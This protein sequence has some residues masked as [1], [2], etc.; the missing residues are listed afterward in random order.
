[1]NVAVGIALAALGQAV[2]LW[3]RA[4][5]RR[6]GIYS[7]QHLAGVARP[8]SWAT[9]GPYRLRHPIYYASLLMIAGVGIAALGWFGFVLALPALPYYQGKMALEDYIRGADECPPR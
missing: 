6:H 9:E 2:I 4:V 8:N 3:A 7:R 1:M 5:L